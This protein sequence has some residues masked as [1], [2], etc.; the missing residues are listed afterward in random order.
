MPPSSRPVPTNRDAAAATMAWP[1]STDPVKATWPTR[2]SAT[3][4]A[5]VAWSA[6]TYWNTPSGRPTAASPS[7]HRSETN[8]VC[9][10]DL[11]TTALP[12]SRAGST[13]LTEQRY[14]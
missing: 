1:P 2:G 8:G 3:I 9:D 5:T 14:G 13:E 7:A 4:R 10:A 11:S 12:A 6:W